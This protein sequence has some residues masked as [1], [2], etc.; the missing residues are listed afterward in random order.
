[1][2]VSWT[3]VRQLSLAPDVVWSVQ[4]LSGGMQERMF[5]KWG[6]PRALCSPNKPD[7]FPNT[8]LIRGLKAAPLSQ[9]QA[10]L[11]PRKPPPLPSDSALMLC[12]AFHLPFLRQLGSLFLTPFLLISCSVLLHMPKWQH[13]IPLALLGNVSTPTWVWD[14]AY[15]SFSHHDFWSIIPSSSTLCASLSVKTESFGVHVDTVGRWSGFRVLCK[16]C[17]S[18]R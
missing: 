12:S 6:C 18:W 1:M 7:L 8:M 4:R 2:T 9:T 11:A 16:H 14:T 10:G 13:R 15:P 5:V 17:S 3:E